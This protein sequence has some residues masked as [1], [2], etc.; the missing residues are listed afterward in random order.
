MEEHPEAKQ[1]IETLAKAGFVAYYAGGWVR[2]F[3]LKHPSDDIDIATNALPET[4]MN[5]FSKTIPVGLSFGIVIVV[6]GDRQ[7]EVATFR[8]DLEHKDGRRPSKICFTTAKEDA[9]RRDFTIN[10]MFYDPLKKTLIDYVGGEKDLKEKIVRSIGDAHERFREDR[11]RMIRAIRLSIRLGFTIEE[12]TE[13]AIFFHA[14][15]LF[16]A[17]SIERVVQELKKG[18]KSQRFPLM[19]KKLFDFH[20]LQ[21]IFPYLP[22]K[23]FKEKLTPLKSYP[24]DAP[25]IAF[26]LPLFPIETVET[27]K[28]LCRFLKLS[29]AEQKFAFFLIHTKQMLGEQKAISPAQWVHF[30]A[31]AF[32][33]LTL[34]ILACHEDRKELFLQNHEKRKKLLKKRVERIRKKD[35]IIRAKDLEK[36]GIPEGP[37]MGLLLKEAEKIFL[38]EDL[39]DPFSLIEK[40]KKGPLWPRS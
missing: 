24:I 7:Y 4:V 16:P 27:A 21:Q 1:I 14:K 26:L 30:Y 40:L 34:E 19:L 12:K 31:D 37:T 2:D 18:L 13:K 17:T 6:I 33:D 8:E 38:E 32:A 25:L 36:E 10:G 23:G 15:E 3:L 35:P 22:S 28:D 29:L 5:L 20:L 9:K 39:W 11:L